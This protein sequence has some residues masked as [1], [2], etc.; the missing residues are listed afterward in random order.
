MEAAVILNKKFVQ[1]QTKD[2]ERWKDVRPKPEKYLFPSEKTSSSTNKSL[3]EIE[4]HN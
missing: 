4:C 3:K 1:V 2:G